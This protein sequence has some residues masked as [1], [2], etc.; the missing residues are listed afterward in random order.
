MTALEIKDFCIEQAK[1][2]LGY[3]AEYAQ[4][5]GKSCEGVRSVRVLEDEKTFEISLNK[6]IFD[7]DRCYLLDQKNNREYHFNLNIKSIEYDENGKLLYI[8]VLDEEHTLN[9][10]SHEHLAIVSDLTFL[11]K[12]IIDWYER[13]GHELN[14]YQGG[15]HNRH[16]TLSNHTCK[17]SSS[18]EAVRPNKEQK[19][20]IELIFNSH[21]TYVWGPPGTGKTKATLATC[22]I[23]Y[24]KNDKRILIVA[25]TNVALEQVS[26]GVLT[27][28]D[29]MGFERQKFIRLG[30]PSKKFTLKYPEVCE[31]RGI[32]EQLKSIKI[33]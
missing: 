20:A 4:D 14:F 12:N 29:E 6:K 32:E 13:N 33:K 17:P 26:E 19:Q 25:P 1:S 16:G 21:A 18:L 5:G 27:I 9:D 23:N 24:I 11:I 7:F 3:V 10:L 22:A 8:I 2:Y 30:T 31:I 28:L 15:E